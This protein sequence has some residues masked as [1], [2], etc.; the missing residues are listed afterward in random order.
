MDHLLLHA[1]V[2]IH[3]WGETFS[4]WYFNAFRDGS[5]NRK[6]E[7]IAFF[8]TF[9]GGVGEQEW[10]EEHFWFIYLFVCTVWSFAGIIYQ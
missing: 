2:I 5:H 1:Y 6:L 3:M 7:V 8:F 9:G 10:V 4:A